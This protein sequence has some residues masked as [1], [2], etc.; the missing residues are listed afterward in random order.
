MG[1]FYPVVQLAAGYRRRILFRRGLVKTP[2]PAGNGFHYYGKSVTLFRIDIFPRIE[3]VLKPDKI[4]LCFLIL[5]STL[6]LPSCSQSGPGDD[7]LTGAF[8]FSFGDR[9]EG[10]GETFLSELKSIDAG[11]PPSPDSRFEKYFYTVTPGSHRIYQINAMTGAHLT[12]SACDTLVD[13]LAD[14]LMQKYY[15]KGEAIIND[16]DEKWVLQRN[17]KRSVSLECTKAPLQPGA[18]DAMLY[19]L[20]LGYLDYNLAAEA[21]KE[22]KKTKT[23]GKPDKY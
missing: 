15:T 4:N 6:S 23:A 2:R 10:L 12:R 22:W 1:Y 7:L 19:Q 17:T 20:S 5:W 11:T 8:G 9:P 3:K 16:A 21:Y 13:D 18:G 14:E